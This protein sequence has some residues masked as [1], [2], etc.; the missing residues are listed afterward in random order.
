MKKKRYAVCGVSTRAIGM[1]IGPMMKNFSVDTFVYVAGKLIYIISQ[2]YFRI[3][4][5]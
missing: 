1:Y 4:L 3:W 2:L 5:R